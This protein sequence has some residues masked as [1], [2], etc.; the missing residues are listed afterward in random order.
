MP[1]SKKKRKSSDEKFLEDNSD[2]YGIKVLPTKLR[3]SHEEHS[4]E[5]EPN[6]DEIKE[7]VRW[8]FSFSLVFPR[9]C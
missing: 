8:F 2:Y 6:Q 9:A 7:E 5:G 3:S 4:L 1:A